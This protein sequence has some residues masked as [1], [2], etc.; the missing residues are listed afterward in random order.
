MI[1]RDYLK[2]ELINLKKNKL[3]YHFI[4][5]IIIKLFLR[6]FNKILFKYKKIIYF[7]CIKQK[8]EHSD[9]F[10]DLSN[11]YFKLIFIMMLKLLST[12]FKR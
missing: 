9:F 4:L 11:K 7:C 10:K 12:K 2:F 5:N 6:E 8:K 1:E 3:N